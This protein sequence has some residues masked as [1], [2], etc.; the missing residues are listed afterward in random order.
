MR[1]GLY[2][3]CTPKATFGE[4]SVTMQDGKAK[5]LGQAGSS[6]DRE[7]NEK[8]I[9]GHFQKTGFCSMNRKHGYISK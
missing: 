1:I 7:G 4:S 6:Q 5:N 3:R 9:L 2:I 8:F